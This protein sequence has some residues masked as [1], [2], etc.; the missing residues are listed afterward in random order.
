MLALGFKMFHLDGSEISWLV[1]ADWLEDQGLQA[2]HIRE[3]INFSVNNWIYERYW[4]VPFALSSDEDRP[5]L[6][7]RYHSVGTSIYRKDVGCYF[8]AVGSLMYLGRNTQAF[9]LVGPTR[10]SSDLVNQVGCDVQT[11]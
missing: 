10:D 1:Y 9:D 11:R 3:N 8:D 6:Q 4:A 5:D 2:N 7:T